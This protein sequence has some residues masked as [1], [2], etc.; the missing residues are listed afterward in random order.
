MI[1]RLTKLVVTAAATLLIAP[2]VAEA[3]D[4][5]I[6]RYKAPL[7]SVMA[8]YNWTGFYVGVV[9]GYASGKADWDIT[10][11]GVTTTSSM[12]PKGWLFGGTIGYNFQAGSLVYGIEADYSFA[13]VKGSTPDCFG[14][15]GTTCEVSHSSLATVRGRIGYAF[16]RWLP[17]FT[18]GAAYGTVRAQAST[19]AAGG[20]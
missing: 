11:G 14:A 3:A 13:N 5:P 2:I 7:R 16:D 20:N 6:P 15:V 12:S 18:A 8:Y 19:A 9:G 4:Q 10:A 1:S 17:Y